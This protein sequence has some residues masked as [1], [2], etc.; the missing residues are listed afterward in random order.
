MLEPRRLTNLWP[1]TACYRSSFTLFNHVQEAWICEL[2]LQ[3]LFASRR[4]HDQSTFRNFYDARV[5]DSNFLLNIQ[6]TNI[7]NPYGHKL[8]SHMQKSLKFRIKTLRDT[9]FEKCW[10]VAQWGRPSRVRS[11]RWCWW[12]RHCWGGAR[13]REW[14]TIRCWRRPLEASPRTVHPTGCPATRVLC[15]FARSTSQ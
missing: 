4:E 5:Q 6:N 8:N 15:C 10:S 13:A 9:H 11:W 12:R 3:S 1:S 7:R 2:I 14:T